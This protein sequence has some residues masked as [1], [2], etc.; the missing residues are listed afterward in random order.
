MNA[1]HRESQL[2][3]CLVATLALAPFAAK[4]G[5]TVSMELTGVQGPVLDGV[6]TSPY[7]AKIGPSDQTFTTASQF[8]GIA[9]TNVYCDDF[10]THVSIGEIWNATITNMGALQGI[11]A[12]LQSLKFDTGS[13]SN[14]LQD[15]MA[16]AWL[17]EDIASV[18]QS[19]TAGQLKAG[20][21]SYALWGIFDPSAL[22]QLDPS[23]YTI[24]LND[25]N[26]A[27]QQVAGTDP[28]DFSNVNIYTPDPTGAS[29]EYLTVTPVP[30]PAALC[31]FAAG[32]LGCAIGLR[33]RRRP[34]F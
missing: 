20:Q 25:K 11:T 21:L 10:G 9:N 12:P 32:L 33:S 6:Y 15:Y 17:A 28:D 16:A 2:I 29:Q 34:L 24:A 30:E 1:S 14:Q 23:D 18:D 19:T 5:T 22:S 26:Y 7:Q 27:F 13:L 31:L 4:A 8:N 3:A